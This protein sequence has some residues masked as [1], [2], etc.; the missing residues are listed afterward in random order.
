MQCD[1]LDVVD[2]LRRYRTYSS[3]PVLAMKS[4]SNW[5]ESLS[6]MMTKKRAGSEWPRTLCEGSVNG[7]K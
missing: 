3:T 7:R 6:S 4:T 1:Y 2:D 5:Y